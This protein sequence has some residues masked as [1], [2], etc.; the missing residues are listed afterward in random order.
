[1]YEAF[2]GFAE[3]P[4]N[5]TP[6]P[7]FLYP[8]ARHSEAFAHLAFGHQERGGFVVITGEVG[9]G[10]TTLARSFLARLGPETASA[11]VL[12]P[13]LSAQEL[14]STILQELGVPAPGGSLKE[15]VDA[16]HRFLLEARRHGRSVVLLID[17]A[18][19]LAVDVL[20]QVRLISN[21]ETDTEKLIQIVLIGQ[22][23][24]QELLS[25]HALRQLAQRVTARYHLEPLSR[26][27]TEAYVRHRI[28][29]AGGAGKLSFSDGALREVQRF[30][31]GVPRL[32]NLACDRALLGGYARGTRQI[33]ASLVR[34]AVRELRG[35]PARRWLRPL[36]SGAALV[37][38]LAAGALVAL[39]DR[40]D[41]SLPPPARAAAQSVDAAGASSLLSGLASDPQPALARVEEL[42]GAGRLERTELRLGSD[43]LRR[44]DLPAVLELEPP[45]AAGPS[46]LALLGLAGD[47]AKVV[48]RGRPQA[49]PWHELEAL[50]TRRAIVPWRDFE[51]FGAGDPARL[52]R[53][54]RDQLGHLGYA[55]ADATLSAVLARFQGDAGLAAD[56]ILGPRTLLAL[57]ARGNYPRPRL[58]G[59]AR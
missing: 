38:L 24:L 7:K 27:E 46:Y 31:R 9:T 48:S 57:Y 36:L 41:P 12:Y 37:S 22:S 6:D 29:V 52:E 2:Y 4:F 49:V 26:N 53:W 47:E 33:D 1:L 44:L 10:K 25:R 54:A 18:Q 34:L 55:A 56:G 13:A 23:E 28:E 43:E 32:V 59:G 16:L 39:R 45:G 20:E 3:K 50:W 51:A 8:S 30:S 42:W 15:L 58:S 35:G 19:D 40:G 11:F 14:L 17:E 5:L 21:L